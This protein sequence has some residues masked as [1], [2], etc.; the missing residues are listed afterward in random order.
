MPLAGNNCMSKKAKVAGLDTSLKTDVKKTGDLDVI[1]LAA[2]IRRMEDEPAETP[3]E[4]EPESQE[5][6][7]EPSELKTP[8][9]A[10]TEVP[11]EEGKEDVLS[12]DESKTEA[13]E[14]T[15]EADPAELEYPKFKKRV[16]KLTA[17]KHEA[18]AQI[19]ALKARLEELQSQP[20]TE[21][22]APP[23]PASTNP[24][25]H[26]QS[27]EDVKAEELN[28]E[29]VIEW[30]SQNEDG[31]VV[32]QPN[33]AEREYDAK[34]VREIQRN[35][36]KALR[37]HLPEQLKYLEARHHFDQ[38]A[39]QSYG[40]WKDKT[41]VE[42]QQAAQLLRAFPEMSRFPDYKINVGDF[43]EGRRVRMAKGK[44]ATSSTP[45]KAPAQ[46]ISPASQPAPVAPSVARSDAA[47]KRFVQSGNVADLAKLLAAEL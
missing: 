11:A 3:P 43:I 10:V 32:K 2:A 36:E 24:F 26:V 7:A 4:P 20:K 22:A 14:P 40:W 29:H 34:E 37:K 42:Y 38:E 46:P 9:D 28:A 45:K 25:H 16:D 31:A 35:A 30:C 17:E 1:D 33:G 47:R 12:Q 8:D 44:P 6:A 39:V 21:E 18:A 27:Y 19:E 13:S 5:E 15:A 23:S 41:A